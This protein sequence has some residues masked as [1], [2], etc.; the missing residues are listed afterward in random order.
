M[1]LD[2]TNIH[3]YAPLLKHGMKGQENVYTLKPKT[4]GVH[5]LFESTYWSGDLKIPTIFAENENFNSYETVSFE[6]VSFLNLVKNINDVCTYDGK[7]FSNDRVQAS[8]LCKTN[9]IEEANYRIDKDNS[10]TFYLD[11]VEDSPESMRKRV[12]IL[13]SLLEDSSSDFAGST[14]GVFCN[15][16]DMYL[17]DYTSLVHVPINDDLGQVTLSS[18]L[19]DLLRMLPDDVYTVTVEETFTN[20]GVLIESSILTLRASVFHYVESTFE[21]LKRT[22]DVCE[23]FKE[24]YL[25]DRDELLTAISHLESFSSNAT[26]HQMYFHFDP[27]TAELKLRIEDNGIG[28]VTETVSIASVN[29]N[30]IL[31]DF[32]IDSKKLSK[33]LK[34]CNSENVRILPKAESSDESHQFLFT[35]EDNVENPMSSII[36]KIL[37]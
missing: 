18:H 29:C 3:A 31:S 8:L 33:F 37:S 28:I 21:D 26:R 4:D 34:S 5:L 6:S 14:S 36:A 19:I 27:T 1:Q 32:S 22:F 13:N 10:H 16:S 2:F 24:F 12:K 30:T 11:F 9:H 23:N 25:F 15:D 20:R 35:I 7:Q 17:F